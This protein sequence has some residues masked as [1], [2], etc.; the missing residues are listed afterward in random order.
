MIAPDDA[1]ARDKVAE[2]AAEQREATEDAEAIDEADGR[3]RRGSMRWSI[4]SIVGLDCSSRRRR[5]RGLRCSAVVVV[6]VRYRNG[7]I[8]A[9]A[10]AAA[11][12]IAVFSHDS[13]VSRLSSLVVGAKGQRI[14]K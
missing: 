12:T 5:L 7:F 10:A 6:V 9:A 2:Q 14:T 3:R 8:G 11:A 1:V 4:W 13:S